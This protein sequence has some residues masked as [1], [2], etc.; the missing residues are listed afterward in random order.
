M[1]RVWPEGAWLEGAWPRKLR[2]EPNAPLAPGGEGGRWL[3]LLKAKAGD[4]RCL[5]CLASDHRISQCRDPPRCLSCSRSG[6]KARFCPWRRA[7]APLPTSCAP[8]PSSGSGREQE[9]AAR[10]MD[11][12]MEFRLSDADLRPPAVRAAAAR[13][14]ERELE[15]NTLVAVQRDG[16]PPLSCAVVLRDAPRQLRIPA[17]DLEVEGLSQATFLLRFGSSAVRN[18][19]LSARASQAAASSTPCLG[20]D[21]LG[22]HALESTDWG[23][24]LATSVSCSSPFDESNEVFNHM[25]GG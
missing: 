23:L 7:L 8:G 1:L 10:G 25:I 19:A 4:R 16:R 2:R 6:H 20:V 9:G 12:S 24:G 11:F 3:A 17:Q 13:A 15:L 5:N 22:P 21:R 14:A 18:A